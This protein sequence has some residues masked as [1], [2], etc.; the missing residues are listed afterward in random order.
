MCQRMKNKTEILTGKLKLSKVSEKLWTY[1]TVDFITKLLLVSGK[2]IILV[3]CDKLFKMIHFVTTIEEILAE[4]LV[5]LFRDNM[6]KLHE[7][8]ESMVSDRGLQFVV[9]LTR[10]LNRMLEIET[11]LLILFHPQTDRQTE[12]MN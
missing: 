8:P 5:R 9:E 4:G 10:E 3:V 11:K 2:N 1:L 6:W 12:K 7:L